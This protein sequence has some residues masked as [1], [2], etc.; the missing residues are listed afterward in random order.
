MTKS[1]TQPAVDRG[2]TISQ[3]RKK[4]GQRRETRRFE[5]PPSRARNRGGAPESADLLPRDSGELHA[6]IVEIA[7]ISLFLGTW[8]QFWNTACCLPAGNIS[9]ARHR[10]QTPVYVPEEKK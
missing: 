8:R 3:A 2:S 1:K 4:R 7:A 6:A 5:T 9:P 10:G